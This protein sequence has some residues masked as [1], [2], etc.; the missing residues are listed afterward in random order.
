MWV[1]VN[2]H[3]NSSSYPLTA[4]RTAFS[5]V[6]V[7]W[8]R[9]DEFGKFVDAELDNVS[10]ALG[11]CVLFRLR[12]EEKIER[13]VPNWMDTAE[14]TRFTKNEKRKEVSLHLRRTREVEIDENVAQTVASAASAIVAFVSATALPCTCTGSRVCVLLLIIAFGNI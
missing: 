14:R 11:L 13:C 6:A 5:F 1:A 8:C 10:P 4:I 12:H 3:W 9:Y 7:V 2:L